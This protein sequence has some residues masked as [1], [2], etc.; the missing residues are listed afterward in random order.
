MLAGFRVMPGVRVTVSARGLRTHMG[1]RQARVHLGAGRPGVSTGAGPLTLYASLGGRGRRESR[2]AQYSRS[3]ASASKLEQIQQIQEHLEGISNLHRL[4]FQAAQPPVLKP[5]DTQ[6]DEDAIRNRHRRGARRGVP[7]YAL[8][9]RAMAAEAASQR[10][11]MEIAEARDAAEKDLLERMRVAEEE[12]QKL[13]NNDESAVLSAL[14]LAF[15]DNDDAPVAP[16]GVADD[17]AHLA[18]MLPSEHVVPD[19]MPGVTAAGNPSLRKATKEHVRTWYLL[20]VAGF[21]LATVK[22]ALAAAPGLEAVRLVGIRHQGDSWVSLLEAELGRA[23]VDEADYTR[24][25]YSV[26]V[27]VASDISIRLSAKRELL[28]LDPDSHPLS[29]QVLRLVHEHHPREI[30]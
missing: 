16:L 22:E 20:A 28:P 2:Q 7:W 23:Q 8:R 1:P 13:L 5:V 26:L 29:S 4:Q 11:D 30:S 15:Q 25:A 12:W 3:G 18:V 27:D 14:V 21:V 17:V 24:D 6:I 10:A 9:R 19:R